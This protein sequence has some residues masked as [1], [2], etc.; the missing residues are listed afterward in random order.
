MDASARQQCETACGH[1]DEAIRLL[2]ECGL[3]HAATHA[4]HCLEL[5]RDML[6]EPHCL[7]RVA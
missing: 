2:D 6:R 4:H 3:F 7:P 1:L 5:V